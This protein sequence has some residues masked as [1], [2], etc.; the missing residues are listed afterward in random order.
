MD[1]AVP[2][3]PTARLVS[4]RR[5][6]ERRIIGALS[7]GIA[8]DPST[9]QEAIIL[10]AAERF[11][12]EPEAIVTSEH[13]AFYATMLIDRNLYEAFTQLVAF[14]RESDVPPP[15]PMAELVPLIAAIQARLRSN[16]DDAAGLSVRIWPLAGGME[17]L[18]RLLEMLTTDPTLSP[19]APV[20]CDIEVIDA[21]NSVPARLSTHVDPERRARVVRLSLKHWQRFTGRRLLL[22][23]ARGDIRTHPSDASDEPEPLAHEQIFSSEQTLVVPLSSTLMRRL[24]SWPV[25]LP[26]AV[27]FCFE[28][29]FQHP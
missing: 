6:V 27:R 3:D 10:A 25:L 24:P 13:A 28:L 26:P 14:G 19:G 21:D 5:I 8:P 17:R 29:R 20:E 1:I 16:A 12:D 18:A 9:H 2:L 23:P 7:A 15:P 11:D 22:L 4:V